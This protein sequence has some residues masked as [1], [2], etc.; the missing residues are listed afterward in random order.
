MTDGPEP[1]IPLS[2]AELEFDKRFNVPAGPSPAA[3][4]ALLAKLEGI[5][6]YAFLLLPDPKHPLAQVVSDH[7]DLLDHRG[8]DR[9]ALVVFQPPKEWAAASVDR[10]KGRLG[11]DF[12]A[13]WQ[14]WQSG[15]GLEP[16]AAY[17]Y[18]GEFKTTPPLTAGDL[19]CV[20]VTCDLEQPEAI[21]R[22]V[23]NWPAGD[24]LGFLSDVIDV[25][26]AHLDDPI[27]TRLDA[28]AHDLTSTQ[29]KARASLGRI[30][31]KVVDYVVAN[32]IKVVTLGI[33][34]ALALATGG[35]LPLAAGVTNLLKQVRDW[36][37]G[38]GA[39]S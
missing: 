24:L 34:L 36:L 21:V 6:A 17:D 3:T 25:V 31:H 30:S 4:R 16:G 27:E 23:P 10:W 19:P 28:I 1:Y 15:Y 22:S 2:D 39:K 18:V 37:K 13:T 8:G 14:Q 38:T 12:A 35:V 5:R 9:L 11:D 7:W 26:V 29:A 32:P 20:V 33:D